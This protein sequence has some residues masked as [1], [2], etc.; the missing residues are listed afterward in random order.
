M[1]DSYTSLFLII[2]MTYLFLYNKKPLSLMIAIITILNRYIIFKFI[3]KFPVYSIHIKFHCR[4]PLGEAVVKGAPNLPDQRCFPF[5]ATNGLAS[6]H[7]GF[8]S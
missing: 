2:K 6:G 1:T 8:S 5:I 7:S 3:S 4:L